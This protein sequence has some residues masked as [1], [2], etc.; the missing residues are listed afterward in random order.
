MAA[1]ACNWCSRID[2]DFRELYEGRTDHPLT[3]AEVADLTPSGTVA[4]VGKRA[5]PPDDAWGE[6]IG[7]GKL[8]A[9]GSTTVLTAWH[10]LK[11]A[12]AD[13]LHQP[14]QRAQQFRTAYLTDL[15]QELIDRG[16]AITPIGIRGQWRE[17]D[18][19]QDLQ[20]ARATIEE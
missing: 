6:Y 18:T 2:R 15:W 10:Q 13:R 17:I 14:F 4:R 5:L 7:L 8:S 1:N 20:R 16:T 3:E 11:T 19:V 12:Y 9:N